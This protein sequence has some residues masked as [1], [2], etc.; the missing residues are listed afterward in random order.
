MQPLMKYMLNRPYNIANRV[1]GIPMLV[2]EKEPKKR[3]I[4]GMS[5]LIFPLQGTKQDLIGRKRRRINLKVTWKDHTVDVENIS[6]DWRRL[7]K[8]MEK[9]I[10][11]AIIDD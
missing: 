5:L 7:S 8:D 3:I 2:R 11:Q 6:G 4:E 10:L 1:K 9:A